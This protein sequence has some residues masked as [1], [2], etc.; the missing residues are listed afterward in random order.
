[1]YGGPHGTRYHFEIINYADSLGIDRL[2]LC[3][4]SYSTPVAIFEHLEKFGYRVVGLS[5][6]RKPALTANHHSV[7]REQFTRVLALASASR[8]N[9]L[10]LL[11]ENSVGEIPIRI[12]SESEE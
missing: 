12:L 4:G 2:A 5:L 8:S 9:S 7:S 10:E 3:L 11:T 6:L 1:M